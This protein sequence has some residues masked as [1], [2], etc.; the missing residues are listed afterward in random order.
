M[1]KGCA[2][3]APRHATYAAPRR[4]AGTHAVTYHRSNA[5]FFCKSM[6]TLPYHQR[7]KHFAIAVRRRSARI[8]PRSRPLAE[9]AAAAKQPAACMLPLPSVAVASWISCIIAL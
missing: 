3:A 8:P 1:A 6:A 4:A 7:G 9:H 2:A 5:Y